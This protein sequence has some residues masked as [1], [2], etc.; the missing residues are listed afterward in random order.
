[1]LLLRYAFVCCAKYITLCLY[2]NALC[3]INKTNLLTNYNK[4]LSTDIIMTLAADWL[5]QTVDWHITKI[6]N[7][8]P[9]PHT[10]SMTGLCLEAQRRGSGVTDSSTAIS[11]RCWTHVS[12]C[13]LS[14]RSSLICCRGRMC[15][16]TS[17]HCGLCGGS[18]W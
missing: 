13:A 16:E 8:F 15:L 4:L 6:I 5:Q 11:L 2:C 12:H 3:D 18:C 10:C 7:V 17:S 9:N 1:M 14:A